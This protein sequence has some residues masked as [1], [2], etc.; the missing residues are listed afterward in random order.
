MAQY[1]KKALAEALKTALQSRPLEKITVKELVETCQINRQTFYYHFQDIFDLLGWI[2]RSEA[3]EAIRYKKSYGTWQQGLLQILEYIEENRS[4]CINTC[5]SLAREHLE[6]FLNE[7]LTDLL[8]PVV[9]EIAADTSISDEQKNFIIAFY[10][11]AFT[12]TLLD[13]LKNGLKTPPEVLAGQISM[14]MDGTIR[15]AV[16][17][18]F[19]P[20]G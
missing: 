1:T 12:G 19:P 14:L 16:T 7:T 5:R 20:C 18:N 15:L 6:R 2:Y 9:E 11:Y 10:S 4:L 3:I 8:G 17:R 13:W